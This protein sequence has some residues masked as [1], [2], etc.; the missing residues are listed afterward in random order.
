MPTKQSGLED[1]GER[2]IPKL[3]QKS[4][5]YGEHL[6]RYKAALS[7][8]KGKTVLDIACG[9]GYGSQLLATEAK[10]VIGMDVSKDAVAYAKKHYATKNVD[11][12]VGD[13]LKIPLE[14]H[15]V[16]VV[17]SLETIEHLPTP[18]VFVKEVKRILK[19]G[20]V[21]VV[22]TPNDDEFTEGNIYHVH[23]F[24][25]KELDGLIKKYFKNYEYYFQGSWF[26]SGILSRKHFEGEFNN[27]GP[28]L[29]KSFTQEYDKA[30]F[31]IALASDDKITALHENVVVAD[32]FSAK[33]EQENHHQITGVIERL[34]TDINNQK[35]GIKRLEAEKAGFEQQLNDIYNSKTWRLMKPVH[36]TLHRI[37]AMRTK[38]KSRNQ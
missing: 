10:H 30:I 37:S 11:Y 19:P 7:V 22:S 31:Y 26:A 27:S 6:A 1:T 8:V 3:H 4:I 23:E 29:A 14:D 15:S 18:E 24:D 12:R 25:F 9:T 2:L 35:T 5:T 16:D 21:F 32:V 33:T 17:I 20:G 38:L 34:E 28:E 13:A 36:N